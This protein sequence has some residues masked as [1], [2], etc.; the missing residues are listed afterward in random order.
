MGISTIVILI[1][2]GILLIFAEF[3]LTP[4]LSLLGIAGFLVMGLGVF[5]SFYHFSPSFGYI[6]LFSSLLILF[7]IIVVALKNNTWDHISLKTNT[8]SSVHEE[9]IDQVSPGDTG[10]AVSRLSPMGK[11][12]I[13]EHLFEAKSLDGYV[14]PNTEIIIHK[15]SGNIVIVKIKK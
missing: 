13:G 15:V 7:I 5:F 4:G 3:L 1:L 14:D 2:L 10:F 11:V 9:I 12:Q 6:T 8:S